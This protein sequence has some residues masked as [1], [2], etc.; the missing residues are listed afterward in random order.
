MCGFYAYISKKK[1]DP[2][3][4]K[5]IDD[6]DFFLAHRGPDSQKKIVGSN[7]IFKHWRLQIQDL[8]ARSNQPFYDKSSLLLF[9]GEIYNYKKIKKK[10]EQNY[11]FETTGD[12][13]VLFKALSILGKDKTLN[14]LE[15]MFSFL[16]FDKNSKEIFLARDRFGQKP[17]YYYIDKSKFIISSEIKAIISTLKKKETEIDILQIEKYLY[18]NKYMSGCDTNFLNIK[19]LDLGECLSFKNFELKIEKYYTKKNIYK[20]KIKFTNNHFKKALI[21]TVGKHMIADK[22]ICISLSGGIDSQSLAHLVKSSKYSYNLKRAYCFEYE[23]FY[24]ESKVAGEY[25]KY[26]K[27]PFTKVTITKND[28]IKNFKSLVQINEGPIGG[29]ANI[30]MLK[31]CEE[32]KNDGFNILLA[33]YGMDEVIYGYNSLNY[34]NKKK[35]IASNFSI[36][37]IYDF[38]NY[39]QKYLNDYNYS[40]AQ[41]KRNE[42]IFDTKIP[43]TVGM[44]DRFSMINSV[45]L[46]LPFLDHKFIQEASNYSYDSYFYKDDLSISKKPLR[47]FMNLNSNYKKKWKIKKN[48]NPTPQDEWLLEEPIKSWVED[49]L[50]DA[51]LYKDNDFLCKKKIS[52]AWKKFKSQKREK[53]YFFW[54]LLN[55]YYLKNIANFEKKALIDNQYFS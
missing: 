9:N 5:K 41:V 20:K 16:H 8:D 27:I 45:E 22:E 46:R 18:E 53:G 50:F 12:T 37:D 26:L 29:M 38:T 13:E 54:Q 23:N 28:I 55:I 11:N 51:K 43:R 47:E 2:I 40:L 10:L 24:S 35:T 31:L 4:N 14:L 3:I 1:I 34:L 49:H 44:C 42:L 36:P 52:I 17:L 33:G 19:Q 32:V 48:H 15:G 39:H 25:A 21:E 30:S 6:L 7:Y